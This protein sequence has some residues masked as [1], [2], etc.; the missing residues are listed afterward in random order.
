M[1]LPAAARSLKLPWTSPAARGASF[2]YHREFGTVQNPTLLVPGSY[3]V[4]VQATAKGKKVKH[5]VSF[6]DNTCDFNPNVV[7]QF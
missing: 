5:S 2:Q 6:S 1:G 7:V 3:I 4:S